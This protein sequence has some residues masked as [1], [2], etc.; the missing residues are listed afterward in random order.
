ME[1]LCYLQ[2]KNSPLRQWSPYFEQHHPHPYIRLF[3]QLAESP[4]A[5][6]I[7]KIG[8]WQEFMR[9]E[10]D[11]F[12]SVRLLTQRPEDALKFCQSRLTESWAQHRKSLERRQQ[13][14]AAPLTL[15]LSPQAGRGPTAVLP[16]IEPLNRSGRVGRCSPSAARCS[17]STGSASERLDLLGSRT[18]SWVGLG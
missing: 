10:N 16:R 15:T 14:A 12:D 8:I 3:R 11:V 1:L 17:C 5:V 13:V 9:E 4:A 2:Q 18:G 7:P 6:H